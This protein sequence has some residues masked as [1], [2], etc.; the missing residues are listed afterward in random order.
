MNRKLQSEIDR[1]LKKINEGN[2]AFD[3]IWE[4]V[5][6]A[7]SANQKEKYEKHWADLK[8][9]IKRLQRYRDSVKTWASQDSIKDKRPLQDARKEIEVNMERFKRCERQTKTKTYSK[10]ALANASNKKDQLTPEQEEAKEWCEEQVENLRTQLTELT[11][12]QERLNGT[13]RKKKKNRDRDEE[14]LAVVQKRIEQHELHIAKLNG[15]SK[16]IVKA[17]LRPNVI[18]SI[19]ENVEYY[20]GEAMEDPQFM[21]DEFLYEAVDEALQAEKEPPPDEPVEEEIPEEPALEKSQTPPKKEA[22]VKKRR[23]VKREKKKIGT[24]SSTPT[25][26]KTKPPVVSVSFQPPKPSAAKASS[27]AKENEG[28]QM[29]KISE[30]IMQFAGNATAASTQSVS[31]TGSDTKTPSKAKPPTHPASTVPSPAPGPPTEPRQ[32]DDKS[33]APSDAGG[34]VATSTA[35]FR[36]PPNGASVPTKKVPQLA[37][38]IADELAKSQKLPPGPALASGLGPPATQPPVGPHHAA[39]G[40]TASAAGSSTGHPVGSMRPP[41]VEKT[42]E[43]ASWFKGMQHSHRNMIQPSE[44]MEK[45]YMPRNPY[46]TPSYFPETPEP[47]LDEPS[48]FEKFDTDTLFFIFYFQQGSYQQYLAATE[49]KR[50]AWRYHKKYLTWFQRHAEPDTTTEEYE[51]GNYVYFD[52]DTS[53]CPRM[54]SEFVFEYAYLEDELD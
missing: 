52:Y 44:S 8:K 17:E 14:E 33:K 5:H 31:A 18:E 26:S 7:K 49:L 50:G 9:E 20:V 51:K 40:S 1:T 23:K 12:Q 29:N 24:P 41:G 30:N 38:I 47:I 6:A 39:P 34:S 13:S 45:A 15:L 54:K 46:N 4:R 32:T 11:E 27:A 21:D 25:K 53:W 16:Y 2:I 42:W 10:E 28:I 37:D 3:E 43:D 36:T 48:L 19:K 22:R 35:T